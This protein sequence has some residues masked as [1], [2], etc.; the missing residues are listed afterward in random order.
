MDILRNLTKV[1]STARNCKGNSAFPTNFATFLECFRYYRQP[2]ARQSI[3]PIF[4]DRLINRIK[5][6]SAQISLPV[7]IEAA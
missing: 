7:P 5:N 3:N 6:R 4:P 1:L 2:N